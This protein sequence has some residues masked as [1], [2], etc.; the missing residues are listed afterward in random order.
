M[1]RVS[2]MALTLCAMTLPN[3]WAEWAPVQVA[4]LDEG[5]SCKE[6]VDFRAC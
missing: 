6:H 3:G 2:S 4:S 1:S 5:A